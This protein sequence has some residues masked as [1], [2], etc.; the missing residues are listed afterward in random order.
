MELEP[1]STNFW[2]LVIGAF[3][4]VDLVIAFIVFRRV[5]RRRQQPQQPGHGLDLG[6]NDPHA[7]LRIE[8]A[9]QPGQVTTGAT[10][11]Q[12]FTI[13]GKS[14]NSLDELPPDQR[15]AYEQAM[16]V[17]ADKNGDGMPDIFQQA[18]A[19][20]F[21]LRGGSATT[22][23]AQRLAELKQ[24]LDQGLITPAEYERKRVEILNQ[25]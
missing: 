24:M 8:G 18:G 6:V 20:V 22:G 14:Y 7:R 16:S 12:S 4:V 11:F 10:S 13:N 9:P 5:A 3:L 19:Q 2:F 21:D 25:L 17:F 1:F 15:K 23:S